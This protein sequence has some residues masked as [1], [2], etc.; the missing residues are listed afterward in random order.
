MPYGPY[1]YQN[2]QMPSVGSMFGFGH[3][4]Y[5]QMMQLQQALGRQPSPW[6]P[7]NTART[8]Q[9]HKEAIPPNLPRF[10]LQPVQS[11]LPQLQM[12]PVQQPQFNPPPSKSNYVTKQPQQ[13]LQLPPSPDPQA[14]T[15]LM[16]PPFSNI[17]NPYQPYWQQGNYFG[18]FGMGGRAPY[19]SE[20]MNE[21]DEPAKPEKEPPKT[22]SPVAE[23]SNTTIVDNNST[24]IP[25]SQGNTTTNNGS[26]AGDIS[27]SPTIHLN[28]QNGHIEGPP[29][30]ALVHNKNT[31][32][33]ASRQEHYLV[34]S[35]NPDTI[36]S[37][38]QLHQK[39]HIADKILVGRGGLPSQNAYYRQEQMTA[40]EP[41]TNIHNSEKASYIRYVPQT[42]SDKI[43]LR[44]V[45]TKDAD[46]NSFVR[47]ARGMY[48]DPTVN[49][50][51]N[52]GIQQ[53]YRNNVPDNTSPKGEE[54][55]HV[56]EYLSFLVNENKTPNQ[57]IILVQ[58]RGL[59]N[60]PGHIVKS[61]TEN[62]YTPR[63]IF[64][65]NRNMPPNAE[66]KKE[67]QK[68]SVPNNGDYTG[69][70][71][72]PYIKSEDLF[73]GI[74][75]LQHHEKPS[76][77][78]NEGRASDI[79][80]AKPGQQPE[81][82]YLVKQVPADHIQVS[83]DNSPKQNPS[84]LLSNTWQ[85]KTDPLGSPRNY[86]L[87]QKEN[88][89]Y[90]D[91][92]LYHRTNNELPSGIQHSENGIDF[93]N[94][95]Y[96]NPGSPMYYLQG[97]QRKLSIASNNGE[98]FYIVKD[99]Q[100]TDQLKYLL[101]SKLDPSK[102]TGI[103]TFTTNEPLNQNGYITNQ[104]AHLQ[105]QNKKSPFIIN[106]SISSTDGNLYIAVDEPHA[107]QNS[108]IHLKLSPHSKTHSGTN[109]P[110]AFYSLQTVNT[111]NGFHS[112]SLR[113]QSLNHRETGHFS[114]TIP[115]TGVDPALELNNRL[116]LFCCKLTDMEQSHPSA[117]EDNIHHL[118]VVLNEYKESVPHQDQVHRQHTRDVI[119]SPKLTIQNNVMITRNNSSNNHDNIQSS[120]GKTSDSVPY[121]AKRSYE[122]NSEYPYEGPNAFPKNPCP[123]RGDADSYLPPSQ[124]ESISLRKRF[125]ASENGHM[126]ATNVL[127]PESPHKNLGKEGKFK[128]GIGKLLE[129]LTC[130][131]DQERHKNEKA[132]NIA[133]ARPNSF[134]LNHNTFSAD[135]APVVD[136]KPS[137]AE[138]PIDA[139]GTMPDC[140][141]L[142]K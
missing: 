45:A 21:D 1:A 50:I 54:N 36:L 2:P 112:S 26:M 105:M 13:P 75:F 141:I 79:G 86:L 138:N 134:S 80:M 51:G 60:F 24:T 123:Y 88:Y 92:E 101:I 16:F 59:D 53:Y 122:Q 125:L 41:L 117:N 56:E 66:I 104:E 76:F 129:I 69:N 84:H 110:G 29:V 136:T 9:I 78:Q 37:N 40:K 33:G 61:V 98:E 81:S 18:L 142:K 72:A 118:Q 133:K 48:H 115:E 15:P 35:P 85:K 100:P 127:E 38:H 68:I 71:N 42:N 70:T 103:S 132:I 63:E 77:Y 43:P 14:Q 10:H 52:E 87:G 139:K 121:I 83:A 135:A 5:L 96:E 74:E 47:E 64:S 8:Q 30:I 73:R 58:N 95:Q 124:D 114:C 44:T 107:S 4:H 106:R 31:L 93:S 49:T 32:H 97:S 62:E 140:L 102:N 113:G 67:E 22:E 20:E 11:Q 39:Y 109:S 91:T 7:Q 3:P 120:G 82:I 89:L 99:R 12:P 94:V 34:R 19:N 17:M 90:S 55:K 128:R 111:N 65:S 119:E 130:P 46:I 25:Q 6:L 23:T 116:I 57:K 126:L 27:Q 137:D 131:Q 108:P 28:G